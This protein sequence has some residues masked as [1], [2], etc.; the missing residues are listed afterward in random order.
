MMEKYEDPKERKAEIKEKKKEVR[1][2][3]S[4]LKMRKFDYLG[5]KEDLKAEKRYEWSKNGIIVLKQQNNTQ[6][7]E[8]F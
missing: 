5:D 2:C 7:D 1:K 8:K 3:Q 4:E 6:K